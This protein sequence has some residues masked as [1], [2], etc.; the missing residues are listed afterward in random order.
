MK[1]INIRKDLVKECRLY[2]SLL[3]YFDKILDKNFKNLIFQI[4]KELPIEQNR[5]KQIEAFINGQR[6]VE[7]FDFD[8][9]MLSDKVSPNYF[10]Y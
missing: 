8:F 9:L 5:L 10:D 3:K 1:K 2:L 7:T 4:I 6:A